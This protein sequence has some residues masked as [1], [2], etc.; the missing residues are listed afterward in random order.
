M[1]VQGRLSV[2]IQEVVD[3]LL[4]KVPLERV[5]KGN[6]EF[7]GIKLNEEVI[8]VDVKGDLK[9]FDKNLLVFTSK[10]HLTGEVTVLHEKVD[11]K[12]KTETITHLVE[13]RFLN[14]IYGLGEN[15]NE[16]RFSHYYEKPSVALLI[17]GDFSKESFQKLIE[18][19]DLV[20]DE[21]VAFAVG[22]SLKQ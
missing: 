17:E 16:L 7:L 21:A 4:E 19:I 6:L 3:Y 12:V 20:K 13:N 22:S 1:I 9:N 11:Y 10:L 2:K 14:K 18:L 5:S 8:S 15:I